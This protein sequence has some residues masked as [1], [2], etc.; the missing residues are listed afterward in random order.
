MKNLHGMVRLITLEYLEN[1]YCFLWFSGSHVS[2]YIVF[3]SPRYENLKIGVSSSSHSCF[4]GQ[5]KVPNTLSKW[6]EQILVSLR[7]LSKFVV[8]QQIIFH[9]RAHIIILHLAETF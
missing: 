9:F 5:D 1:I 2:S 6:D 3:I 4:L 8:K 7:S